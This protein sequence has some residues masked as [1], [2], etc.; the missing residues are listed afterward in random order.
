MTNYA[1]D[2]R[3]RVLTT[4]AGGHVTNFKYDKLDRLVEE[5]GPDGTHIKHFYN[6]N[7]QEYRTETFASPGG[8]QTVP[9]LLLAIDR[10]FDEVGMLDS[11]VNPYGDETFYKYVKISTVSRN[12]AS[13][14]TPS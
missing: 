5:R 12:I 13:Q 3:G 4:T 7:S 9:S 6:T 8:G 14:T 11:D 1:Y 2:A 10:Q